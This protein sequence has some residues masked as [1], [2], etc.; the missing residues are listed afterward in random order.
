MINKKTIIFN[1]KMNGSLEMVGRAIDVVK[2]Q[3]FNELQ[4][5]NHFIFCLPY[6]YLSKFKDSIANLNDEILGAQD[7]SRF[8][9]NSS[10]GEISAEMLSDL[11]VRNVILGHS[12]RREKNS[13]TLDVV[14]EK[15]QNALNNGLNP[16]LCVGE[17]NK[18]AKSLDDVLGQ[19]RDHFSA[20]DVQDHSKITIAYE[21]IW[22]IGTGVTPKIDEIDAIT[23]MLRENFPCKICYGGSVNSSNINEIL[24][25]TDGV[26]VGK[27][28]LDLDSIIEKLIF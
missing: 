5:E 24:E 25:K 16:I 9:E 12:E 18:S 4:K 15:L 6:L 13:E 14:N 27:A 11:G 20:I 28:S 2:S 8:F 23:M 1:W 17:K 3:K 26:L 7:C 22:S 19:C 21:P 10:T